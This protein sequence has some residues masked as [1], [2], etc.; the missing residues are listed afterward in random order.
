MTTA[1]EIM[2]DR[3]VLLDENQTLADA[4]RMMRDE[5]VG[6]LPVRSGDG[7]LRG[8][9][10]DRDIVVGPCADGADLSQCRAGDYAQGSVTTVTADD[11]VDRLVDVMGQQQVKRLPVMEGE[12]V[13][14]IV[15]EA[16]LAR[17]VA[18]DQVEEFV[19]MVYG[20][21]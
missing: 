16:D 4:A 15:S 17:H 10:T 21:P 13:I 14:G 20:R 9:V 2:S 5:G 19:R 3:P 7:T 12:D 18:D 1:R 11:D 6:A 8:I